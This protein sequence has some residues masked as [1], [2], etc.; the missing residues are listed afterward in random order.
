VLQGGSHKRVGFDAAVAVVEHYHALALGAAYDEA[1]DVW[2]GV[3][4]P[5]VFSTKH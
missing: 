2:F 4:K 5:E 3:E 1:F